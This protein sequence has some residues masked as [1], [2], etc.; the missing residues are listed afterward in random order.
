MITNQTLDQYLG[1]L[2]AYE[3]TIVMTE[4]EY[5]MELTSPEKLKELTQKQIHHIEKYLKKFKIGVEKLKSKAKQQGIQIKKEF[6]SGKTPEEAVKNLT[7]I[8]ANDIGMALRAS[9]DNIQ[10]LSTEKKVAIAIGIFLLIFYFNTLLMVLLSSVIT[11]PALI[12]PIVSIIIAPMVEELAKNY[13]IKKE[14]PWVGTGVVFGLELVHYLMNVIF[15]GATVIAK[16]LVVRVATLLMHFT[17][18]YV[19]KKIIEKGEEQ[20][21]NTAFIAWVVGFGIHA[22]WNTLALIYNQKI[23]G[24]VL[25]GPSL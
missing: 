3:N 13:F 11:N 15:G 10:K 4:H 6:D 14:M 17:T 20:G 21:K 1:Y 18:T 9:K 2:N 7:K 8:A 5:I 12:T 16:F 19:Q 23:S 25:G 24:W 22:L